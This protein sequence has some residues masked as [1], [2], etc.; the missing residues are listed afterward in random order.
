MKP[1]LYSAL[2]ALVLRS[3]VC[4]NGATV[5]ILHYNYAHCVRGKVFVEWCLTLI[6]FLSLPA[7]FYT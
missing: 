4:W 6:F 2:C 7:L 3:F 5:E 1:S